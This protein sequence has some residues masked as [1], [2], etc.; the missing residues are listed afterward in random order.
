MNLVDPLVINA[1]SIGFKESKLFLNETERII[2]TDDLE[3]EEE[4]LKPCYDLLNKL[5]SP[6]SFI[7]LKELF[8][9]L[10]DQKLQEI[11]D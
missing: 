8:A 7:I 5:E 4:S 3:T 6:T 9:D 1:A 11:I 2:K 10:S